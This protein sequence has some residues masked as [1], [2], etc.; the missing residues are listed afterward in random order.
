MK[1][2]VKWSVH[3][4]CWSSAEHDSASLPN[5]ALESEGDEIWQQLGEKVV[6]ISFSLE[7]GVSD[8]SQRLI[9]R[10]SSALEGDASKTR[11]KMQ[12]QSLRV[13]PLTRVELAS[14]DFASPAFIIGF[15]DKVVLSR[16]DGSGK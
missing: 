11:I 1:L 15:D 5:Y 2:K 9:E 14:D 12:R 16:K 8:A 4:S 3:K 7:G 13:V 6:P 10:H